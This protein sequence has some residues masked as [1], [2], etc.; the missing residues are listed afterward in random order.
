MLK[1]TFGVLVILLSILFTTDAFAATPTLGT[2]SPSSGSVTPNTAKTFTCTYSDTDGWA[3][4]GAAYLLISSST[5]ALANAAY[6]YY[7]QNANLLYLR[8]DANTAWLGGYTP[9][10]ANTIANSQV[11]LNCVSTTATGTSNTLTVAF[12]LT[13]KPAYSG[14]SYSMY[15]KV[16]DDTAGSAGWTSK[17]SQVVNVPPTL[18]S[19]TPASGTGQVNVSQIF[20]ATYSDADGWQNIQYVYFLI[21]ASTSATTN[22]F[23]GYYNQNTNLL[24][25]RDDANSTWLGGYAP[26]SSNVIENSYTKIDCSLTTISSS[27]P[28]MTVNWAVTLK[29]PFTGAKN[30]YLYVRDDRNTYVSLTRVGTW[31]IANTAPQVGTIAPSEGSSAVSQP[32][33]IATTYSDADGYLNLQTA[34]L[35]VNASTAYTNCFYAYY[36]R[37]TN[38]LYLRNDANSA[39]LGGYVPGSANIIENTYV[40]LDCAVTNVSGSGNALTINWS[41]A[42]KSTFTGSKKCYLN[43]K[44]TPGLTT[45]LI[46]KGTW[47]I[48]AEVIPPTGTIQV[49]NDALYSNIVSATLTLLAQDEVGGSGMGSGAQMQF[50]N[51][52]VTWSTPETY[53]TSKSWTLDSTNGTKTVYAKFKDAAG[54]W[55]Q[56]FSDTIVLDTSTPLIS[57]SSQASPTNQNVTL[58]YSA[59][60]NLTP[61]NQIVISGDNSPYNSEGVHDVILTVRDLAGNSATASLSFTIDKTPPA[62]IITSPSSGAVI[63]D[64]QV[65]VQGT[66]DGV[67]FSESCALNAEGENLITKTATDAAGNTGSAS[68]TVVRYSGTLIGSG[69]GEINS[70]DGKVHLSIPQGALLTNTYIKILNINNEDLESATPGASTLLSAVECK[71]YGLIFYKPVLIS[72]TLS[73]AEVPG[74]PVELGLYD[75]VQD[76]ILPTGQTSHV[77]VDGY[78]VT[79]SISHFST[80][81]ALA[82]LVSQGQPIGS[83]VKIPLPDL[84]TG[85]FGHSIPITIPPGRKGV[86]PKLGL[87]YRSSNSNSWVGVGFTLNPGYIV[88]STR[89][90]PPSYVDT[91]DSFYFITDAGTTELVHLVDNLYQSKIESSFTK[92]FKES[93]DTWKAVSKDGSIIYFG[94]SS[95]SKETSTQGT[96]SWY[97]TKVQDTNGNYVEY[98]YVKDEGKAYLSRINYTGNIIG[99]APTNTVEFTLE[100]RDDIFSSYISSSKILTAKRLKEIQAKVNGDLVWRYVL[101]YA[102]SQDTD[103]SLLNSITQFGADGKNLPIQQLK[104]QKSK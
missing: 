35:L 34:Y 91:Q 57:I 41:I 86:Q 17:G 33:N 90:G 100:S 50:S 55:S 12:N 74:T 92:F 23:Y 24:Y 4:L 87:N 96:F 20:T 19:I 54:N 97:V 94:Q 26:G 83:G 72:Y 29:Q 37:N 84:L 25:L 80:Y 5:S 11:T 3:N 104:Y 28:I 1:R 16:T 22:C 61:S 18:G 58:S 15:L 95:D 47:N 59:S 77:P 52:N 43:V 8:N 7:D 27:G 9:G 63:E 49:N 51:D 48:Q 14:K 70:P 85:S 79:F 30:T 38:K 39:W 93:G 81:A 78:T 40:R 76:K 68:V 103:R 31:T 82:N 99:A 45:G 89:L 62:I 46:Q 44:D 88:R 66:I 102:S 2:I 69:G 71:P 64:A 73:Q 42:F 13:F 6:L 10:S 56:S 65:Q 36:D 32:V 75:S 60:D 101:E 53:A 98:Q 67:P 21:S